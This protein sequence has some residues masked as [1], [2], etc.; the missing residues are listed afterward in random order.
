MCL[1]GTYSKARV[2]KLLSD[3]FPIQNGLKYED[4]LSSLL[5]SFGL[6][7][8]IRGRE[9]CEHE[10]DWEARREHWEDLSL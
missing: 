6:E 1:N 8:A 9:R 7:Y 5:F 3:T 10:F 4:A 2:G